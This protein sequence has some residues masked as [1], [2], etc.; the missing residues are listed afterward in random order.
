MKTGKSRDLVSRGPQEKSH[1]QAVGVGR[2]RQGLAYSN[3]SGGTSGPWPPSQPPQQGTVGLQH[4]SLA[5]GQCT[6][7][8][9]H[10][11]NE[12]NNSCLSGLHN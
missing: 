6:D 8:G 1:V 4:K 2:A 10:A 12:E 9:L 5:W 3:I 7:F 11:G